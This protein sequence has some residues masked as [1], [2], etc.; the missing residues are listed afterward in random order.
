MLQINFQVREL[1]VSPMVHG[2]LGMDLT[3]FDVKP[4][5]IE[6]T[7]DWIVLNTNLIYQSLESFLILQSQLSPPDTYAQSF[8]CAICAG[9]TYQETKEVYMKLH[10]AHA[11]AM[12]PSQAARVFI[13]G[14][15]DDYLTSGIFAA[16][17]KFCKFEVLD[18]LQQGVPGTLVTIVLMGTNWD[19]RHQLPV[20]KLGA[21]CQCFC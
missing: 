14:S 17:C 5:T 12:T 6:S 13:D 21:P 1:K 2:I 19:K 16:D 3:F 4:I 11:H 20:P 7:Y 18:T 9:Q 15:E 8:Q 10:N